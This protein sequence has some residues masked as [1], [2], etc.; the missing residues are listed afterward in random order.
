MKKIPRTVIAFLL[1]A[2]VWLLLTVTHA[3]SGLAVLIAFVEMGV[4]LVLAFRLMRFLARQSIWRLRNRLMVTYLFIGVM[5]VVLIL[6]LVGIGGWIVAGQVAVFLVSAELDRRAESLNEPAQILG[7]SSPETRERVLNQV[8]AFTLIRFPNVRILIHAETDTKYPPDGQIVPP[9][10]GWGDT[11]GLVIQKGRYY[12]WTHVTRG[13][14]EVVMMEPVTNRMLS[15]LVPHLGQVLLTSG[16]NPNKTFAAGE[17]EKGETYLSNAVN[18]LD[19]EV[20]WAAFVKV[21]DW[22]RPGQ[23][24]ERL[25]VVTTRPSALKDAI[26][27]VDFDIG[28]A[29]LYLF[30]IVALLF[31]VVELISL[32]AG[33]SMSRTI[34][35]AVHNLYE[36][37]RRVTSGD[38]A[39]RIE[40]KGQDQL[41]A[42]SSSF[43]Q[44]T[45]NLE[46]LFAV[47]KEKERLQSELQIATEVQAQLFP[48]DIPVLRTIHLNGVCKPARMVS[49]DYYD[50]FC[51]NNSQ[52]ALAI[53]DVAGKGISAALL[54]AAIQSIMRA[55]LGHL[56]SGG[57]I[58]TSRVVSLLNRQLYASTSPEKYATFFFAIYDEESRVL[59]YTNAGHLP[60][61]LVTGGE[62]RL[63][64][65][66]GTVVGAFPMVKYEEKQLLLKP[67]D[68]LIA[69]TDGIEEPENEYGEQYGEERLIKLLIRNQHLEMKDLIAK[70][71]DSVVQWTCTDEMPDDMTVLAARVHG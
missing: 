66:T 24:T 52:V 21:A 61:I 70:V 40:V 68:L 5:P 55:Q 57:K 13:P 16:D 51:L 22:D 12:Q 53:G 34:T 11:K 2:V 38:F 47:E 18:G 3:A 56:D 35:G 58:D 19:R 60:P 63:L 54:M 50:F 17:D 25:L 49:G 26:F 33:I 43:N 67:G 32:V 15:N 46:R 64:E 14:T 7:W 69:Y 28:Q 59:S 9:P 27:G 48:K 71:M 1:L 45:E 37:T 42:L 65:V 4:G 23:T 39:H 30:A 44:M 41:A 10:P 62:A 29:S 8:R 36:G 20:T 31:F 6:I